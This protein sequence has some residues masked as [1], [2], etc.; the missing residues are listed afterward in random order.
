MGISD[1]FFPCILSY[2]VIWHTVF[3]PHWSIVYLSV[4]FIEP[5]NYQGIIASIYKC[6]HI[7]L[8]NNNSITFIYLG[9]SD[10][11]YFSI[12]V[13]LSFFFY[14]LNKYR[15]FS[16]NNINYNAYIILILVRREYVSFIVLYP[17]K[18]WRQNNYTVM[19][20]AFI[21]TIMVVLYAY[22]TVFAIDIDRVS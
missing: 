15:A 3:F 18:T 20:F 11:I 19:K 22:V 8:R 1:D 16:I 17:E 7:V 10:K 4:V 2:K 21:E 5:S 6:I 13:I 12:K 9:R 14:S